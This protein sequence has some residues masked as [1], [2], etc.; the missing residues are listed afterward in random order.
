[1]IRRLLA[2]LACACFAASVFAQLPPGGPPTPAAPKKPAL[3]REAK[4]RYIVKQLD[5][6]PEQQKQ[7]DGLVESFY[8]SAAVNQDDMLAQVRVLSEE[9]KKAEE[10][11]NK[12]EMERITK[13]LQDLGKG[14]T[15]EPQ[16]LA[17]LDQIL[18]PPQKE[19][20]KVV[21]E[22]LKSNPSGNLRAIDVYRLAN[23]L[24]LSKEQ[25]A[26]LEEAL[27]AFRVA[28]TEA[29]SPRDV[30]G[31][32]AAKAQQIE[33][34]AGKIRPILTPDQLSKF[35]RRLDLVKPDAPAPQAAGGPAKP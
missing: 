3:A 8:K 31:L 34:L 15:D 30:A 4:A 22:R 16:F 17:N 28:V 10:A 20:L 7:V 1:M 9:Y 21:Q 35:N 24:T 27:A 14:E 19:A 23:S 12:E 5:L 32:E 33:D 13:R 29:P 25:S 26:K 2:P 11:K 6:S 18:T